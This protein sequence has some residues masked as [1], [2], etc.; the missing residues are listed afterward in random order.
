MKI[1]GQIMDMQLDAMERI[2]F[3]Y[4]NGFIKVVDDKNLRSLAIVLSTY[5][6]VK[7]NI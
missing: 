2:Q 5:D 6:R 7:N 1:Y 3:G 4:R